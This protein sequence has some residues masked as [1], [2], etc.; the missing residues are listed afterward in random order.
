MTGFDTR[1]VFF[2][3]GALL[4][5]LAVAM[6]L[7]MTADL[8]AGNPDWMVFAIAFALTLFFGVQFML[9]NRMDRIALNVRQAFLLTALSWVVVCAFAAVPFM[10]SQI[11]LS[12]ADAYFEAMSALTTTGSTVISGLDRLPPGLLLWRSLLQWLGGIGIIG[13]AIA[14]LPF[15]RVGG[16]QLFRSESSDRSDKVT[17]RASDLAIAVGWIYLCLTAVC[18]VMLSYA[19]MSWF[20]AVNHAMTAVST[21]GFSTRDASVAGWNSPAIEWVLV[22]FMVLGGMPFVRFISLAQ[23]RAASFWADTQ[24]R[25]YLGFLAAASFGLSVWLTLTRGV[26]WDDAIRVTTFN[27]VSVVT[28][29]GYASI[30]YERWGPMAS[31][32]FFILTF[33]GG[34]TG[35]TSGGMK[36]FRFEILFIVLRALQRRLYSPNLVIPLN[37]NDKPVNADIMIS[38]MSFGFVYLT[39]VVIVAFVLGFLGVDLV[40]ALSGAATAVSNVGPGLGPTIG[41]T[42]NFATLPDGAKWALAAGMLLGRLEFFTVLVVLSPSF[43]R[44]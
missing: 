17:P 24:I 8:A 15:L 36:I 21:G 7:P 14:I 30:D 29:T 4:S 26:P 3:I 40:S 10:V 13:M 1:P 28:T 34:C 42:G 33:V 32:V 6:L 43:W 9:A 44:R 18:T 16:M 35:S 38:V 41:P 12:A 39:S 31:V 20:D 22:V 27:V 25:W 19:G 2:I 11:D 5:V 37:Y 23:G